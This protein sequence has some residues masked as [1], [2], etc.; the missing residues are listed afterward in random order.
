MAISSLTDILNTP[1]ADMPEWSTDFRSRCKACKIVTLQDLVVLGAHE[2]SKT[3]YLGPD[4]FRELVDY[5]YAR[6]LLPVLP[7]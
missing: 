3:K 1:L 6:Q 4:C 2:I 5:L 7:D